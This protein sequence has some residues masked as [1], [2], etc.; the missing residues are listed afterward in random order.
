MPDLKTR[1]I[2]FS[3]LFIVVVCSYLW[4]VDF[5]TAA[6]PRVK[7][8]FDFIE[9]LPESSII[10]ISFDHEASSLPEIKP[11]AN[12]IL[13]H[14]FRN[15]LRVIGMSLFAEGTAIGYRMM[16]ATADEFDMV[17]GV[18]YLFLGFK[19]QHISTILGMGESISRVFPKDYLDH[20]I[21]T[22]A[23]MRQV[24]NYD[25]IALVIS[26]ADGDRPAQWIEY[27]AARYK[28]RIMAVLTAA[29]ITSYDPYV[30]SGQLYSVVAGLKGAAEYENLY[31]QKG[32]GNRGMLAQTMAHIYLIVLIVIGNVIY[33]SGRRKMKKKRGER[34]G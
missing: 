33:L 21:D 28:Q 9:A 34:S 4:S 14:A 26:I 2:I 19:P 32:G 8:A 16:T 17:Y 24:Q 23:I 25:D 15:K 13:R 22:I 20:K 10:L 7:K 12:V 3:G 6:S 18:D 27:G 11:L 30:A 1:W 29:M 5:D 31:G